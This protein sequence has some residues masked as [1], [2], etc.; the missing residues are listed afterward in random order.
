MFLMQDPL[1]MRVLTANN[2]PDGYGFHQ[3]VY[4]NEARTPYKP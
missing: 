2:I 1:D 3:G 4:A